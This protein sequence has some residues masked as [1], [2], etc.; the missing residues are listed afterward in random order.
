MTFGQ[1]VNTCFRRYADFTGRASRSE[2]WW[3]VLFMAGLMILLVV[4]GA[5]FSD[6]GNPGQV[7][8]GVIAVFVLVWVALLL[9]YW[10]VTVRRLHDTERAGWFMFISLIP[11][12]GGIILLVTLASQG[13]AGE[14]D[15]GTDPTGRSIPAPL[16]SSPGMRRCPFCA[17]A[18]QSE[19]RVCRWC[20]RDLASG[21]GPSPPTAP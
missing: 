5:E 6:P 18:I 16:A 11:V 13:T 1:S 9:P 10:A 3:F 12:V 21:P 20:G 4:V 17:E 7:S 14:N 2:F 19:A 8:G 15:Y